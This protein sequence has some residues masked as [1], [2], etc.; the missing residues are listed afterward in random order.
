M[1]FAATLLDDWQADAFQYVET[2]QSLLT[3]IVG[4]QVSLEF[5]FDFGESERPDRCRNLLDLEVPSPYASCEQEFLFLQTSTSAKSVDEM[6]L[7]L[8]LTPD[9]PENAQSFCPSLGWQAAADAYERC[10]SVLEGLDA[11]EPDQFVSM[12]GGSGAG[13]QVYCGDQVIANLDG[14]GGGGLFVGPQERNF[15][16]GG[17]QSDPFG[18]D[19]GLGCGSGDNGGDITNVHLDG[20]WAITQQQINQVGN[21]LRECYANDNLHVLGG[22]GGGGGRRLSV[23]VNN[24]DYCGDG[25]GFSFHTRPKLGLSDADDG[26]QNGVGAMFVKAEASCNGDPEVDDDFDFDWACVCTTVKE[27]A[28]EE[29]ANG[30][31]EA[32]EF[33]LDMDCDQRGSEQSPPTGQ[34]GFENCI[35][36]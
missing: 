35:S 25:Y 24:V 28:L 27:I 31:G 13:F 30:K 21:I 2:V 12:G 34:E 17:Y 7:A 15:G 20:N 8:A 5:E 18:I 1:S 26:N 29:E 36:A 9:I 11:P 23:D 6:L 33:I 16:G 10:L 32:P 19:S 22:G 14:G 3:E 4:A